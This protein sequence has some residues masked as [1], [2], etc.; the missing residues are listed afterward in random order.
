MAEVK[1]FSCFDEKGIERFFWYDSD[2]PENWVEYD[3]EKA[4]Q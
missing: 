2:D 4:P 3:P 1:Y